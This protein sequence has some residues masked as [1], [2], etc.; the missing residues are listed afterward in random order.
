MLSSTSPKTGLNFLV[1]R[2]NAVTP[3]CDCG[4][5]DKENPEA[6]SHYDQSPLCLASGMYGPKGLLSG[7]FQVWLG[8]PYRRPILIATPLH[9]SLTWCASVYQRNRAHLCLLGG[10]AVHL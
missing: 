4:G 2:E 9:Q 8:P 3:S 7:R 10:S 6:Q 5:P 1:V